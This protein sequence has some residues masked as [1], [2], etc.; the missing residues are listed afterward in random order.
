MKCTE[1][2][3]TLSVTALHVPAQA[4]LGLFTFFAVV[5]PSLV[6][7]GPGSP[8]PQCCP[9]L[10]LQMWSV[11]HTE[12]SGGSSGNSRGWGWTAVGLGTASKKSC[13]DCRGTPWESEEGGRGGASVHFSLFQLNSHLVVKNRM[14][15]AAL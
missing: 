9:A 13:L 8:G 11:I 5:P 12:P 2:L 7:L 1:V 4:L 14:S 10:L 15:L 6:S 3:G